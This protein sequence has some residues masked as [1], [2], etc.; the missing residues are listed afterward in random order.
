MDGI[1]VAVIRMDSSSCALDEVWPCDLVATRH[2]PFG[3]LGHRLRGFAEGASLS[4]EQ[5]CRLNRDYMQAH[6]AA[7]EPILHQ[8]PCAAVVIHGQTVFHRPPLSWQMAEPTWLAATLGVPVISDLRLADI[9]M[10]GQGAPITPLADWLLLRGDQPRLVLNLGGFANWTYLPASLAGQKAVQ[11]ADA[12]ACNHVLDAIARSLFDADYDDGGAQALQGRCD[13]P[14]A[15]ALLSL[16][17]RDGD[18]S[19]GTGDEAVGWVDT[20]SRELSPADCARTACS[21]I[22]RAIF[23]SAS[24]CLGVNRISD[25]AHACYVAGGGAL[26]QALV[27]ELAQIGGIAVQPTDVLGVPGAWRE[28][29]AMAYLG[30]LSAT[31]QSLSLSQVTGA[32]QAIVGGAISPPGNPFR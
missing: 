31:G 9:A 27:Q 5:I 3:E 22:A 4:A 2:H 15:L 14:A 18:R 29:I 20:Y 25:A 30:Y 19:L 8:T 1:D 24:A 28:A 13:E 16:L 23:H 7:L 10:G 12:C 26:N 32:N 17:Q 21:A 11:A 6:I